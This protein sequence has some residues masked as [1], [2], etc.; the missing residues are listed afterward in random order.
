[1]SYVDVENRV[2][3]LYPHRTGTHTIRQVL[4]DSGKKTL[5]RYSDV[6]NHP[7]LDNIRMHNPHIKDI[8]DYDVYAFYREPVEKFMSF[9]AYNYKQYPLMTPYTNVFDYY[10]QYGYFAPQVRWLDHHATDIKLLDFS[11]FESELRK[12][13]ARIGIPIDTPIPRLNA[14]DNRKT[15]ADLT[16]EEIDFIKNLYKEDYDFF[17]SRGIRFNV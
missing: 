2:V 7:T 11:K 3:I 5:P 10:S 17:R 6:G 13:F 1:M 15:P 16:Q 14:S 8:Y 4:K 9:I 12:V